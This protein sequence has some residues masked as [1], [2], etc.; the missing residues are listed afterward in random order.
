MSDNLVIL[1]GGGRNLNDSALI[2]SVAITVEH[3]MS[4]EISSYPIEKMADALLNSKKN[5]NII[6][7]SGMFSEIH[8]PPVLGGVTTPDILSS[9]IT[10][11]ANRPQA[12]FDLIERVRNESSYVD[13]VTKYKTYKDCLIKTF[14]VNEDS[15]TDKVMSF[16][17]TFEQPRFIV[18]TQQVTANIVESKRDSASDNIS[19]NPATKK[20]QDDKT[21]SAVIDVID[22]VKGQF[23]EAFDLI[24]P[25]EVTP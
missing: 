21:S 15:T 18:T 22:L 19:G 13:L 17:L 12:A 11:S 7:M 2:P 1:A 8:L 25:P 6:T 20:E 16:Q 9:T 3:S 10:S 5:N 14:L 23:T 24:N 4:N